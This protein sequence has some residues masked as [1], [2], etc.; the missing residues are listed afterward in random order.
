M[1]HRQILLD[2]LEIEREFNNKIEDH[3]LLQMECA[4]RT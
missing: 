4:N 3:H 1:A 2:I